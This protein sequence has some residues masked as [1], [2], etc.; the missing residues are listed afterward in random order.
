MS[1]STEKAMSIPGVYAWISAKDVPGE[2]VWSI[3]GVPDEEVFPS[4][5]VQYVG[6]IVGVIAAENEKAG[7]EA[8]EAVKIDYEIMDPIL[9]ISDAI[10]RDVYHVD[11]RTLERIQNES[12]HSK[13]KVKGTVF[14]RGQEHFYFEP[15]S[16]VAVPSGEKQELTVHFGTQ[17]PCNVQTQIASVLNVPQHKII[18]KSKRTDG[19]FW[20]KK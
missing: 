1:I 4:D 6:Q 18:V 16:A 9:T 19:G 15:H 14:L 8:V 3:S 10:E 5:I 20:W 7:R 13:E 12:I 11:K 17:E 2:N